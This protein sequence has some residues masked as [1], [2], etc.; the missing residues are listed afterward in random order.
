M[1]LFWIF[2]INGLPNRVDRLEAT[3]RILEQKLERNDVKTD[4][5]LDTV[6]I[7]QAHLL[8]YIPGKGAK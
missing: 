2:T 8:H 6:K 5:I 7:I 4:M 1:G 3:V